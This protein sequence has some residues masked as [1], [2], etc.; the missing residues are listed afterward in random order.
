MS[1]KIAQTWLTAFLLTPDWLPSLD[2]RRN[3]YPSN[4]RFRIKQ[5]WSTSYLV[6]LSPIVAVWPLAANN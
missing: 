6:I 4:V 1:Q 3:T 2:R 5:A